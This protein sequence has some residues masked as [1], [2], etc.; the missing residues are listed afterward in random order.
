MRDTTS[1]EFQMAHAKLSVR[2]PIVR[3]WVCECSPGRCE[4]KEVVFSNGN[5]GEP[6]PGQYKP[7]ACKGNRTDFSP[8]VRACR[9][10]NSTAPPLSPASQNLKLPEE[11]TGWT[12]V[13]D[14]T[15]TSP[16]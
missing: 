15:N 16:F 8:R 1:R 11:D 10:F 2:I 12:F 3:E 5:G 7:G 13:A 14:S 4:H 6:R 9:G